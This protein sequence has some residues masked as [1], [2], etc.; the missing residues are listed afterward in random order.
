MTFRGKILVTILAVVTFDALASS[1]SRVFQFDYTNLVWA[2]FLLYAVAGYWGAH[3]RGFI[4]GTVLGALAGLTDSTLGWFVSTW[5]E[6]FSRTG[7]PPVNLP[8]M[9]IVMIAVTTIGVV[10]GLFGAGLCKIFG[11]A[12]PVAM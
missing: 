3:R 10:F 5:I 2:S 9:L 7:I 1:L 8:L 12:E 4:F 11:Q 6:P